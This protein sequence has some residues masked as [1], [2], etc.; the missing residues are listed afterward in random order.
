MPQIHTEFCVVSSDGLGHSNNFQSRLLMKCERKGDRELGTKR[1][2]IEICHSL[3]HWCNK[4]L[5]HP[6]T[7]LVEQ[8]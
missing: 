1:T 2:I 3:A 4:K 6:Y 8:V 7:T 5:Y